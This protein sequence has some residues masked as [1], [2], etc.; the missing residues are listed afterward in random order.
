VKGMAFL[1]V[2]LESGQREAT[3]KK[4]SA[5]DAVVPGEA[6][7]VRISYK[8]ARFGPVLQTC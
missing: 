6:E 8:C 5:H 7:T 2:N 3:R 4:M 1:G